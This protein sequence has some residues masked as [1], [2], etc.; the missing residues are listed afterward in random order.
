MSVI[1]SWTVMCPRTPP[2]S[3]VAVMVVLGST[4]ASTNGDTEMQRFSCVVVRVCET[5]ASSPVTRSRVR[6]V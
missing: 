4:Y 1:W 6:I 2:G 3:P 5:A